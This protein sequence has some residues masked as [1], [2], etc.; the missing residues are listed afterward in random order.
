MKKIIVSVVSLLLVS[1]ACFSQ[2]PEGLLEKS[3]AAYIPSQAKF[4]ILIENYE[5]NVKK[6]WYDMDCFVNGNAKYLVFFN[7]P[8][9]MKGQGQLRSGDIIYQYVRKTDRITQVSARV[10]F[11]QSVLSQE[12]VMSAMLSNFYTVEK[13]E[14]VK[15]NNKKLFRMTL[16]ANTKNSTYAK[17]I[18]DID[19]ETL[20][21]VHR[22]F[23]SYSGQLIKEMIIDEIKKE[24]GKMH[25][26]QF[27]VIDML[28]QGIYSIVTMD[29]FDENTKLS[30]QNF[31]IAY[32]KSH[33]K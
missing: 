19:A 5:S 28:R 16:A 4:H 17:I 22:L 2:I 18:A 11:F 7:D 3:D 30:E 31:S 32:L 25:F 1:I 12:D 15:E 6:Q 21:P 24:N 20:L 23:Y 9:I 29:N 13:T 8:A 10:N 33:V 26:V 27:R 14:E